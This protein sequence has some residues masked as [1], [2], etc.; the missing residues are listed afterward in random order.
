[1]PYRVELSPAAERSLDRLSAFARLAV[2]GVILAL[3]DDPRPRGTT[4]L[5]DL[6]NTWRLRVRI[7]G[8]QWRVLYTDDDKRRPVVIAR[9]VRRDEATYRRP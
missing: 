1:M 2:R 8:R 6:R 3:A 9:V 4:K 7:D 5:A